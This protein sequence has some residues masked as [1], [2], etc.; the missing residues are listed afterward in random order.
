VDYIYTVSHK[1]VC[2]LIFYN[3]MKPQPIFIMFDKQYPESPSFIRYLQFP[4]NTT[5][6]G[7]G[8]I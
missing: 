1:I 5:K 8:R 7:A 3:L 6:C 2:Y 4:I